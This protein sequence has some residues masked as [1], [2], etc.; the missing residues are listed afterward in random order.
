[1]PALSQNLI[2]HTTSGTNTVLVDYPNTGTGVIVYYSDQV[3]GD[4]Y[5]G[6]SDGFHT[7][8]YNTTQDFI[9]TVT[10]QATLA[11]APTS[12]DWFT[13]SNTDVVYASF[14]NRTQASVDIFNFIGNFV[15]VR[16][17]VQIEGG[18]VMSI[19]YNH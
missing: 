10:M 2:F 3:K 16:G 4:G 13:I 17:Y 14:D 9:G 12:L 7:V 15:W 19:Q 11:S 6:G 18:A 1:M 8:A 5:F